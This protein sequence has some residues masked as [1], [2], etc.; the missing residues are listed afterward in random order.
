MKLTVLRTVYKDLSTRGIMLLDEQFFG[1]TL[2]DYA[3]Y[4]PK[5]KHETAIPEGLYKL[6]VD[7]SPRFKRDMP[8]ILNVPLFTGVRIHGGNTHKNTSGCI[9]VAKNKND[10]AVLNSTIQGTLERQL[11][12]ILKA[13]NEKHW[14]EIINTKSTY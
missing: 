9:L 8:R 14:I 1:Y 3:R 13:S 4:T 10:T 6:V 12:K 2:E 11:T 7:Y 5:V